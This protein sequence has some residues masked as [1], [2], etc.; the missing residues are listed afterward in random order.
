[1]KISL[2]FTIYEVMKLYHIYIV[3]ESAPAILEHLPSHIHFLNRY[4]L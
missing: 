2:Q 4:S 3:G 1:M